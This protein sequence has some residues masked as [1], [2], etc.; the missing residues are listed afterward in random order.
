MPR[1]P[2]SP[3]FALAKGWKIPACGVSIP[4]NRDEHTSSRLANPAWVSAV[5]HRFPDRQAEAPIIPGR[6]MEGASQWAT[7]I[8]ILRAAVAPGARA[9]DAE[10]EPLFRVFHQRCMA[11]GNEF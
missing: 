8:P 10:S 1:R 3:R 7:R 9:A 11:V 2:A 5:P 6:G 4:P